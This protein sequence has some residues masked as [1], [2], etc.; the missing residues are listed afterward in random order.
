VSKTKKKIRTIIVIGVSLLSLCWGKERPNV[1]M[2]MVD[3]LGWSDLGCYGSEIKTPHIDALAAEGVVFRRFYN[4]AKCGASRVNL[5]MGEGRHASPGKYNL[6]TIGDVLRGGGY[7]T[8]A[9]GK[10]HSPTNLIDHGFDR[11]YGLRDGMCNHFN[12]GLQR[13]GEPEPKGKGRKRYW[14]DDQLTFETKNPDFQHYFPPSFYSTDVFTAKALEYLSDWE[15]AET[16]RPF[17][18]YL[19]YTAPHDPLHAWPEDISKYEGVYDE[20]YGEIRKAR[21][22]KQQELGLIT[23]D[24]F[25]LSEATHDAWDTLKE[26]EREQQIRVMQIYAAM[27]DRID[28]KVGEVLAQ[29][30]KMGVY[31]NTLILFCSDNGAE[32]VG[33]RESEG[34]LGGVGSYVSLG[35]DWSNVANTPH[36]LHKAR[37][38]NGGSRTPMIMH[39]PAGLKNPGRHTDQCGH[40]VD[41]MPTLMEVSGAEHLSIEITDLQGESLLPVLAD[42]KTP[43]KK[44]IFMEWNSSA[45]LIQDS[46]KLVTENR[47]TWH[48]YNLDTD[49]SETVDLAKQVPERVKAMVTE[50]KRIKTLPLKYKV[51]Q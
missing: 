30:K 45:Y 10:H 35:S 42:V 38:H 29:L 50:F 13:K 9:S 28:Q 24:R 23:P 49:E 27:I 31:E 11:Y 5:L 39:W 46:Y 44:P 48:L 7:H 1:V 43:R 32:T 18:L 40:L 16:G 8:Y 3:D 20:G 14:C 17:L 22:A 12:P 34:E 4:N 47:K 15:Q 21:Y 51:T 33:G 2:I 19:A 26:D 41:V 25:P 6:P 37:A 36:R